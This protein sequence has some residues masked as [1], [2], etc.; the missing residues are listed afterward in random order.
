ME[1][2][3]KTLDVFPVGSVYNSPY[4]GLSN[5]KSFCKSRL[6]CVSARIQF[7]DFQY[8]FVSQGGSWIFG[9]LVR[10]LIAPR[11]SLLF[12]HVVNI[13]RE[14]SKK[15]VFRVNAQPVITFVTNTKTIQNFSI[16]NFIRKAMY[17]NIFL[18][19]SPIASTAQMKHQLSISAFARGPQP[20]PAAGSLFYFCPKSFFE[21]HA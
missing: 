4:C 8:L 15:Q 11:V 14:R 3:Y 19:L 10:N 17:K 6:R 21:R 5:A 9:A 7:S 20:F 18:P 1:K 2:V 13:F 16:V 12:N